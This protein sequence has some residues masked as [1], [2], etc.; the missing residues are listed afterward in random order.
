M[1]PLYLTAVLALAA[2]LAACGQKQAAEPPAAPAALASTDMS[3]MAMAPSATMAKGTGVV[4]A[5]DK[6]ARTVTLQHQAIPEIKWPAMTMAFK[7]N[8]ASLLDRVKAG[9]HVTFD[10]KVEGGSNQVT[11]IRP[12]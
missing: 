5:I 7:T 10:L 9:D 11:A 3:G 6:T 4:I 2:A 1:K 8:P 12:L